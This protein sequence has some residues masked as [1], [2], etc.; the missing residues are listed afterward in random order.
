MNKDQLAEMLS[1]KRYP[2]SS[3]YDPEWAVTNN[4][5]PN[6]LWLTEWLCEKMDLKPGMRVLDMGC[7]KCLSSI[8]LAKEF[9]VQ[10]WAN[11][12]WISATENWQRILDAGLGDRIFP[13]HAE[14]RAL[15]YAESFFDALV[16]VDSY[17]YYGTDDLYFKYF[18]HFVRPGGQIGIVVPVLMKDFNGPV[19][20][21]LTVLGPG[22]GPDSWAEECWSIHTLDWWRNLWERT[23]RADIEVADIQPDGWREWLDFEKVVQLTGN[24]FFDDEIGALEADKGEY[25]GFARLVAR[26]KEVDP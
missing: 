19:P 15:P 7:G 13:M 16:C 26:R 1:V 25:L 8:F 20:Q 11:D 12:L 3:K 17:H 14:A 21:H 10:V 2:R 4:M 22:R 6:A 5:G 9:G 24:H 23:G 18:R